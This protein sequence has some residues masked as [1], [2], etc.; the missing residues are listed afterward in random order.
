MNIQCRPSPFLWES[1]G[2]VL[3]T[4]ISDDFG[5]IPVQDDP[6]PEPSSLLTG[7]V[8]HWKLDEGGGSG[9]RSDQVSGNYLTP[10]YGQY[11]AAGKFGNGTAFDSGNPDSM[12]AHD[13]TAFVFSNSFTLACWV[14]ISGGSVAGIAGR[15]DLNMEYCLIYAGDY[16]Q[17]IASADDSNRVSAAPETVINGDEWYF[18]ECWY[19]HLNGTINCQVNRAGLGSAAISGIYSGNSS[20]K[21]GS[22]G[23]DMYDFSGRLQSLSIWNR[24]LTTAEKNTLYNSGAGLAYPWN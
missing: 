24:L 23:L 6:T 8:A 7:L 20:F 1:G 14:Y 4:V 22:D 16:F 18:V 15:F 21:V 2:P 3:D 5:V 12:T 11:P 13:S 9:N 10:A 17:F 19:D